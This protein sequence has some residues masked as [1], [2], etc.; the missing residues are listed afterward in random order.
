MT[1]EPISPISKDQIAP[2]EL[3]KCLAQQNANP[4]IRDASIS[5]FLLH[6]ELAHIILEAIKTS[7]LEIAEQ[8]TTSVLAALY[9]QRMWSIRLALVLGHLTS[10]S[11]QPFASLWQKRKLPPPNCYNG[12]WG[13]VALQAFEQSRCKSILYLPHLAILSLFQVNGR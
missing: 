7:E 12:E 5:L 11:E 4:R 2:I 6:P 8:I 1:I 10:L 13:L 3:I 9:L